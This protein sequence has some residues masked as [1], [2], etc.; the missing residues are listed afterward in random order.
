MDYLNSLKT[1]YGL[2]DTKL[3]ELVQ[4]IKIN[5]FPNN[6]EQIKT[7]LNILMKQQTSIKNKIP[8]SKF[9]SINNFIIE[10]YSY[11]NE[12]RENSVKINSSV[13]KVYD[14][15]NYHMDTNVI[16]SKNTR[17]IEAERLTVPRVS[18]KKPTLNSKPKLN[19]LGDIDPY[20]LYGYN[21][22]QRIDIQDLKLKYKKYALE[23]HPDKNNGDSK[24]FKIIN[25]AF[26][27]L[28]EDYKLKQNDKQF[29]E[30]KNNSLNSI[31]K[32]TKTNYQNT[33]INSDNFNVTKFNNVYDNHRI[34]NVNDDGYG[35][36]S[37]EN[38]FKSDDIVR[39]SSLTKGNFNSM[40]DNNVKVS[41]AV[42]QYSNPKEL[43]MNNENNCEELGVDK[44][45]NYT[46]NTK[47][48]NYTD[49]KEAHTTSRL[50]DTNANTRESYNSVNDIKAARS[51][52]K[53]Q[54]AEEIMEIEL[55]KSR[56]VEREEKR[57]SN[58]MNHDNDHFENYNKIHNIMLSRR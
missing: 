23:T 13:N 51:N 47:S 1:L 41:D 33:N 10:L 11:T 42:I 29:N 48:I 43:F 19:I 57:M 16:N 44:I 45:D 28:F 34:S 27:V 3:N 56:A 9:N 35:D 55:E 38:E 32:Q 20:K 12:F 18:P 22:N 53:E 7:Q 14:L 5:I 17:N 40:F 36:W 26:K 2:N 58:V 21:K 25:E 46:G 4:T 15:S 30:L 39:N 24:N 8:S 37:K 49:Y 31:E 52:I 50:I 54:T 6:I